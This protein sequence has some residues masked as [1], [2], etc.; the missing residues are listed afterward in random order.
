MRQ[1]FPN[2]PTVA[3]I[4]FRGF[5]EAAAPYRPFS[6]PSLQQEGPAMPDHTTAPRHILAMNNA[7]EV[8]DLFQELLEEEGY[9]VTTQP[10]LSRDLDEIKSMKPDLIVLDYMWSTDD[11]GWSLLQMLR[12]DAATKTIP[13]VLCTG[14][15]A[16]VKELEPHLAEMGIRV[17][18]KPFDLD[19]LLGAI[20]DALCPQ[21]T[22][23]RSSR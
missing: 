15:V 23:T 2:P 14:A 16:Q 5:R 1:L 20:R 10:Y 13:I 22:D 21:A 7:Q 11:A 12:M 8:L 6:P 18:L 4:K 3:R 19:H 17:V 9:R